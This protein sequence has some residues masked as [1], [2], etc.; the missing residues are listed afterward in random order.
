MINGIKHV[1]LEDY[2]EDTSLHTTLQLL[3]HYHGL[4]EELS[5]HQHIRGMYG[6]PF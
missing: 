3:H 2:V 5:T 6:C 4:R 1:G